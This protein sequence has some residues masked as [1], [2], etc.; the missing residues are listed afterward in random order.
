MPSIN[1]LHTKFCPKKSLSNF[2]R[3][4]DYLSAS[5]A[6][7]SLGAIPRT[8]SPGGTTVHPLVAAAFIRWADP[9]KFYERLRDLL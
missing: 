9:D 7:H 5:K 2:W 3:S 1:A 8:P 4:I 6:V